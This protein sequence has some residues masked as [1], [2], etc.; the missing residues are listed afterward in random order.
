MGSRPHI[1]HLASVAPPRHES[2]RS[3]SR[4]L[5][6]LHP[7]HHLQHVAE[8]TGRGHSGAGARALHDQGPRRVPL[9]VEGH[10]VVRELRAGEGVVLGEAA[11]FH[12]DGARADVDGAHEAKDLAG[13]LGLADQGVHLG[14]VGRQLLHEGVA[15]LL[16]RGRLPLLQRLRDEGP[17]GHIVQLDLEAHLPRQDRDLAGDVRAAEV[18]PGVGLREALVLR[19]LDDL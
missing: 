1:A 2:P 8:D 11:E 9:R 13:G 15:Q 12:R 14:V 3:G 18:V 5:R 7:V 16:P 17:H 10:D 4:S 6:F 19:V